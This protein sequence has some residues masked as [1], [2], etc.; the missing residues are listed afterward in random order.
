T[1]GGHFRVFTKLGSSGYTDLRLNAA[2][3]FPASV[4]ITPMQKAP[5]VVVGGGSVVDLGTLQIPPWLPNLRGQTDIGL[6]I[7]G[8][9]AGGFNVAIED[10]FLF[11]AT[12]FRQL[13]PRGYGFAETIRL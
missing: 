1:N 8:R 11:P 6:R 7:G 10:I 12:A 4:A 3:Y 5:E 9:R 2:L 13:I